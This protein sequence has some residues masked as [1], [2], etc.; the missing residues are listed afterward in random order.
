MPERRHERRDARV[1]RLAAARAERRV[2]DA[3]DDH[4]ERA[5]EA[6]RGEGAD[7]AGDERRAAPAERA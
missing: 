7:D 3:L 5:G 4:A 1:G 2:R 6:H